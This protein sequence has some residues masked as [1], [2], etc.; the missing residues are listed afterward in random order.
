MG[1]GR[2]C[3]S[4][5]FSLFM[6][7]VLQWDGFPLDQSWT[8]SY[9]LIIIILLFRICFVH[10]TFVVIGNVCGFAAVIVYSARFVVCGQQQLFSSR[11]QLV[12]VKHFF[13]KP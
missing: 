9:D 12:Q 10:V 2:I 1:R 8:P 6:Q 4:G 7:S 11:K 3:S 13:V 5:T